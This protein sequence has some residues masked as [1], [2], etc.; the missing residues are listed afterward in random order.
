MPCSRLTTSSGLEQGRWIYPKS[1]SNGT[2]SMRVAL[3]PLVWGLLAS[4]GL[5]SPT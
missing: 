4:V 3:E 1:Y 5:D 2:R